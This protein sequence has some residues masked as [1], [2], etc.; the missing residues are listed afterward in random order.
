V[1]LAEMNLKKMSTLNKTEEELNRERLAKKK[2]I[3]EMLTL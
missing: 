3:N 1:G 2:T